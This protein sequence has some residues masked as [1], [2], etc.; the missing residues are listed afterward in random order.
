LQSCKVFQVPGKPIKNMI[1]ICDSSSGNLNEDIA[2]L[3]HQIQ[4]DVINRF[5]V[6]GC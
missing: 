5:C 1:T 3:L 6:V 2:V 4:N